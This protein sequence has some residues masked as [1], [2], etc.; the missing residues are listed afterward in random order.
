MYMHMTNNKSLFSGTIYIPFDFVFFAE[1]LEFSLI[2]PD[3]WTMPLA[4]HVALRLD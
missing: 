3:S 4:Q 1:V 2:E